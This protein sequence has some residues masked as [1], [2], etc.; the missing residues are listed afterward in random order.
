MVRHLSTQSLLQLRI[1]LKYTDPPIWRLITVPDAITLVQ[2]HQVIQVTMG[3]CDCHLHE[4]RIG[5]LRYGVPDPHWGGDPN[6]INERRKRLTSVLKDERQFSYLYDFGD[7][8]EHRVTL[9]DRTTPDKPQRFAVCL[10]GENA[11]PPEDIGGVPG[12]EY[13]K[14]VMADPSHQEHDQMREWYSLDFDPQHFDIDEVNTE[15]KRIKL[16]TA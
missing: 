11:C 16:M 4:Y 1:E 7:D 5:G 13:F 10:A 2:L 6:L 12:F 14:V 3:W 8:W 9:E 15:L